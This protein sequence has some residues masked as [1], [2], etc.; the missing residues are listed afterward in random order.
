M[1][2]LV[3]ITLFA[4]ACGTGQPSDVATRQGQL[5]LKAGDGRFEMQGGETLVVQLLVVGTS[6]DGPPATIT[7]ADLPAFAALDGLQLRFTPSRGQGGTYHMALIATSG[8]QTANADVQLTVRVP[9]TAPT[10]DWIGLSDATYGHR[11]GF[12]CGLINSDRCTLFGLGAVELPVCDAEGDAITVDVEVVARGQPFLG[13]PTYSVTS[14]RGSSPNCPFLSVPLTGLQTDQSYD[15]AV[16][17]TD[18]LGNVNTSGTSTYQADRD[19]WIRDAVR[20]G[21]DQGPCSLH[22]CAC[23]PTAPGG[24]CHYDAECCSGHCSTNGGPPGSCQ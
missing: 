13:K 5:T 10:I 4:V 2:Q 14:T 15:F 16:R 8:S 1:R 18:E 21:F 17:V 23:V 9:E 20:L 22:Q 3:G 6:G 12:I 11:D 7:S 19:G 24:I